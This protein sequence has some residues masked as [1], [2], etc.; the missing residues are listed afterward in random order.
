MHELWNWHKKGGFSIVYFH[1]ISE[2]EWV[3][4]FWKIPEIKDGRSNMAVVQKLWCNSCYMMSSLLFTFCYILKSHSHSFNTLWVTEGGRI[5]DQRAVVVNPY[6]VYERSQ[7]SEMFQLP[8]EYVL[9][10]IEVDFLRQLR[11]D[12]FFQFLLQLWMKRCN[13]VTRQ[14]TTMG[15]VKIILPWIYFLRT[16]KTMKKS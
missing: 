11:I 7:K 6:R 1:H 15:I 2:D 3:V 14:Q 10:S 5:E 9:F 16:S 12:F 8:V 13:R 4:K